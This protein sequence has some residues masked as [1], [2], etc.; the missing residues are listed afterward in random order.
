MISYK[1]GKWRW[2]EWKR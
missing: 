2:R 1:K